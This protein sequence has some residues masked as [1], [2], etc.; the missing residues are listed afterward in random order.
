MLIQCWRDNKEYYVIKYHN[1]FF[2]WKKPIANKL[3][4]RRRHPIYKLGSKV[5][6]T[7]YCTS[8]HKN[9]HPEGEEGV[10]VGSVSTPGEYLR[11]IETLK[12]GD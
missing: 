1:N 3:I 12:V 4:Y 5:E 7:A 2:C 9:C 8:A 10:E 6:K 11:R